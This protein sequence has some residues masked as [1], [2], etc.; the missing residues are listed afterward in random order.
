MGKDGPGS[1]NKEGFNSSDSSKHPWPYF[2]LVLY[3]M[4]IP[5][6]Y[7]CIF[8]IWNVGIVYI[9]AIIYCCTNIL[10]LLI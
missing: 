9:V 10:V 1:E 7:I 5:W 4:N 6:S 3:H 8:Y 2:S